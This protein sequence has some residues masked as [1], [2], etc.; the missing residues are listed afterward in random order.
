MAETYPGSLEHKAGT[1]PEQGGGSFTVGPF[2]S[3]PTLRLRKCTH[4]DHLM[5]TCWG[6]GNKLESSKKK[7]KKNSIQT[8][9]P[10]A[11]YCFLFLFL[12]SHQQS[13][14][15]TINE[16]TLYENLLYANVPLIPVPT[17]L[18]F[19]IKIYSCLKALCSY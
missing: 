10:A 12:F 6:H 18:K 1:H 5:H 17:F 13:N 19:R 15:M 11:M 16:T 8:V 7:K 2:P 14:E 4:A 9:A 3:A